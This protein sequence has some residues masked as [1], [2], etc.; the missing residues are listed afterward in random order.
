MDMTRLMQMFEEERAQFAECFPECVVATL[1]IVRFR[2][3]TQ[4]AFARCY[5]ASR[6]MEVQFH[7][8]ALERLDEHQFRALLRHELA[9]CCDPALSERDTDALA[10][11]VTLEPIYYDEDDIQTTLGGVR[12][13]PDYLHKW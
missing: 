13:R 7:P 9:H 3:A 10:E 11:Y 5:V 1:R 4:R 12:P 2:R 6:K 8:L